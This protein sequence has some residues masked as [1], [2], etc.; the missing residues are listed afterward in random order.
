MTRGCVTP[1][2]IHNLIETCESDTQY[3]DGFDEIGEENHAK[4]TK[5]LEEGHVADEDWL[6][7]SIA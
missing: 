2:Q 1:A 7:V 4:I 6:G 5:A 3:I